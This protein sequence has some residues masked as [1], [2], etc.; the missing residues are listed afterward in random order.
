MLP[1]TFPIL[2]GQAQ[3]KLLGG[4][5]GGFLPGQPQEP[6]SPGVQRSSISLN[7]TDEYLA[8]TLAQDLSIGATS[9]AFMWIRP[10]N[11]TALRTLFEFR[12]IPAPNNQNIIRLH[13]SATN[14]FSVT[15]HGSDATKF[16]WYEASETLINDG[17]TWSHVGYTWDGLTLTLYINGRRTNA[18]AIRNDAI[19]M[20]NTN[21]GIYVGARGNA[22]V[23][24]HFPGAIHSAAV[25]N[26]ALAAGEVKEMYLQGTG[27][28]FN[29]EKNQGEYIAAAALK[30]WWRFSQDMTGTDYGVDSATADTPIP[31]NEFGLDYSNFTDNSSGDYLTL[32]GTDEWLGNFFNQ[33][34]GFSTAFTVNIWLRSNSDTNAKAMNLIHLRDPTTPISGIDITLLDDTTG[35]KFRVRVR[36]DDADV[37]SGDDDNF[38]FGSYTPTAWTMITITRSGAGTLTVYQDG[39]EDSSPTINQE[40]AGAT[41]DQSRV[42]SIGVSSN[43]S[44]DPWEGDFAHASVWNSVLTSAEITAI[45][46]SGDRTFDLSADSG[47][48]ASSADL[49]HWWRGASRATPQYAAATVGGVS[50]INNASGITSA[51]LIADSPDGAYVDFDGS[52]E[53][54]YNADATT[55]GFSNTWTM[56]CWAYFPTVPGGG[57]T[58]TIWDFDDASTPALNRKTI[59]LDSSASNFISATVV[60]ETPANAA[61]LANVDATVAGRW[62]HIAVVKDGTTDAR[63]YVN[64]IL[65]HTDA[66]VLID[67]D[68]TGVDL[69]FGADASSLG[70][71]PADVHLYSAAVW[72]TNLSA[73]G[74][75]EIF[76]HGFKDFNIGV[77]GFNYLSAGNLV[78]WWRFGHPAST[79][80]TWAE[81]ETASRELD[82]S[83]GISR[84]DVFPSDATA[85]GVT[86][87]FDGASDTLISGSTATHGI[88]NTWTASAWFKTDDLTALQTLLDI[89]LDGVDN[90]NRIR[91]AVDGTATNDPIRVSVGD[92]SGNLT[93]AKG[94]DFSPSADTWY[95]VLV[96]YNG[97]GRPQVY[98]NGLNQ[99]AHDQTFT[100]DASGNNTY[101]DT[102]RA[103]G[104]GAEV[105]SGAP[106]NG[107]IGHICIWSAALNGDEAFQVYTRRHSF[108]PRQDHDAY[109]HADDLVHWYTPGEDPASL[110]EDR[111]PLTTDL[112]LTA[113]SLDDT[114]VVGESPT[115]F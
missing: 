42:I 92:S 83:V 12:P 14:G 8:N 32:N 101:T 113:T 88:T 73:D 50:L 82:R 19:T 78:H 103:I 31:L 59:F 108:E 2:S 58:S 22:T 44:G 27:G 86:L 115:G 114:D 66:S 104:V 61:S 18:V 89:S 5:L 29:L 13:L 81:N 40:S 107:H 79:L 102:S 76:A 97:K 54:T 36:D 15:L 112:D 25:W 49:V 16:K 100:G 7:G 20:T 17:A 85:Q 47:S 33:T 67:Q 1:G 68:N 63:L 96:T 57:T 60:N 105:D 11:S 99:G 62:Y 52:A 91:I 106:F 3:G 93:H 55:F 98:I 77:N 46:N 94:W 41:D 26:R 75:K 111:A 6:Q 39:V 24:R 74:V 28:Y 38:E 65:K 71:N 37:T 64:G 51:N 35:G 70:S 80:V 4:F 90:T 34:L 9:S 45:Y 87:D 43:G 21:R 109:T 23:N 72:S 84:A 53:Y 48:Y 10:D 69:S 110:G 30:H 95:H 56:A